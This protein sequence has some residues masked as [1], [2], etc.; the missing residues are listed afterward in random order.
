MDLDEMKLAW[1]EMSQQIEQQKKLTNDI[2]LKMTQEKSSSRLNRIVVMESF[3]VLMTAVIL[4][5]IA[6]NFGRLENWVEIAGGI[7]TLGI[8]TFAV[9]FGIRLIR[10][11]RGINLFKQSFTET[12]KRFNAFTKILGFYKR[13]SIIINA[14]SP[15]F[16]FPV[17]FGMFTEIDL[18]EDP[19]AGLYGLIGAAVFV[20]LV[21]YL[22]IRFYKSNISTVRRAF[23]EYEENL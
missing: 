8:L 13:I 2:I 6:K 12:L 19:T 18:L 14:A 20:P 21:L 15:L 17:A 5:V 10:Q 16:M 22:V 23:N 4:V 9:V 3:G 1:S 7:G 11:A